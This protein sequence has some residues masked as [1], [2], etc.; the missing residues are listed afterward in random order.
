MVECENIVAYDIV[1]A[2]CMLNHF[3]FIMILVSWHNNYPWRHILR[4]RKTFCYSFPFQ[5]VRPYFVATKMTK[6][7]KP[8]AF[9]PT[10]EAYVKNALNTVGLE[11]QTSGC[12]THALVVCISQFIAFSTFPI[13]GKKMGMENLFDSHCRST[14]TDG[15]DNLPVIHM[16]SWWH[17][18]AHKW[19]VLPTSWLPG[20]WEP[21]CKALHSWSRRL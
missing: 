7:R 3:V 4:T 9:K 14:L 15:W 10:P 17:Q 6:I 21:L 12:A 5:S 16:M 2:V 8:S 20:T 1:K 18:I 19:V 13:C 11:T